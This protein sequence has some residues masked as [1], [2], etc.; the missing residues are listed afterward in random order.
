MKKTTVFLCDDHAVFREGLRLLLQAEETIEVIGEAANG[1][2]AVAEAARLRPD[3]VLMG[4][5]MPLLNG[6]E[7]TRRMTLEAPS[8]RVL[9][10]S[11]YSDDQHVQQ[12]LA[13]GA[14]GYLMK[15]TAAHELVRGIRDA[16]NGNAFFSPLIA[17]CLL[18]RW[19]NHESQPG[20]V[21]PLT[22]RQ[23]DVIQLIAE[24]YSNKQM[25]A[26]LFI[27]IKTVEKHRQALMDKLNIHQVA[28]LTRYAVSQRLVEAESYNHPAGDAVVRVEGRYANRVTA[29]S[30]I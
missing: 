21:P 5:A 19:K 10:L 15:E 23:K 18:R 29:D 24:G 22:N 1:H 6:I 26:L 17:G 20:A 3:I 8:T 28:S 27:S 11:S 16:A 13:A 9:I 4:L 7:A 30:P 14:A 2:R 25:A 12:A